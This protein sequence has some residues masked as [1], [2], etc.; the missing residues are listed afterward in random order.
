MALGCLGGGHRRGR[1]LG[2]MVGANTFRNP[3]LVAKMITTLDH[4]SGGRA[5]LG[6]GGAWFEREHVAF[7]L[8]F[9]SSPGAAALAGRGGAGSCAACCTASSRPAT[10]TTPRTRYANDPLPLQPHLPLL[11]GGGG[12]QQDAA[13][14][15]PLRRRLQRGRWLRI[16][17][18]QG[19]GPAPP[20]RRGRPRR[21]RDRAHRQHGRLHHPRR[22]GRGAARPGGDIPSTTATPPSGRTSWSGTPEQVVDKL[23]PYLGIGF[24]HF[25]VGCPS[26]AMTPSRWSA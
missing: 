26:A 15:G 7:G 10:A 19:R 5:M 25:S 3:A 8:E 12:V 18:A 21:V 17:E 20:L 22:P 2:L 14:R 13:D 11:V 23:R 16:G 9:G 4:L 6:I 24:R 1:R